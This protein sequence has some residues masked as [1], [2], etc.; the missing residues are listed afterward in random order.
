MPLN[1]CEA[2]KPTMRSREEALVDKKKGRPVV[3]D[4]D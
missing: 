3:G 1:E 2:P 4:G